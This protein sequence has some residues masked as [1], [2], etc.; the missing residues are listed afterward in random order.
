MKELSTNQAKSLYAGGIS[1]AAWAAIVS[2][3]SFV[4]G[5]FDGIT[6]VLRCN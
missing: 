2:G 5:V 1:A 3:I 4:I 6:R